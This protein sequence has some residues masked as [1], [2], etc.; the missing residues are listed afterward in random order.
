MDTQLDNRKSYIAAIVVLSL[1]AAFSVYKYFDARKQFIQVEAAVSSQSLNG[2]IIA[3]GQMFIEKVLNAKQDVSFEDRLQL[4]NQVRALND[5]EILDQ[6][7]K[8]VGSQNEADAQENVKEL[9]ALLFG[10]IKT[11]T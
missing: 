8:F 6:W 7:N 2:K 10:K 9:L 11:K 1:I 5:P 4:E 3:F